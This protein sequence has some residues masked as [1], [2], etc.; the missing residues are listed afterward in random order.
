MSFK[1]SAFNEVSSLAGKAKSIN[2]AAKNIGKTAKGFVSAEMNKLTFEADASKR[3]FGHSVEEFKQLYADLYELGQIL[4]ANFFVNFESYRDN[5]TQYLSIFAD[6]LTGYLATET[7][8]PL[9]QADFEQVRIGP[10]QASHLTGISEPNLQINF[11]ET[12]D[13]R[14]SNSILDWR[15]LMVNEDGTVNPPASYAVRITVGL[16]SKDTGL[17]DKPV[18]RSFLVAPTQAS[19]DALSGNGVSEVAIIPITFEVLRNFME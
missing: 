6:K 11:V 19:I 12:K 13:G 5:D 10:F 16:F 7:N 8:L 18:Q 17:D 15:D 14:I 4:S 3:W 2:S 9:I 1:L